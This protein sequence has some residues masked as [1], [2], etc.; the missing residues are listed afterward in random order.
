MYSK[1]GWGLEA[2]TVTIY[3]HSVDKS[4]YVKNMMI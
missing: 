1:S 2:A 3:F 4:S